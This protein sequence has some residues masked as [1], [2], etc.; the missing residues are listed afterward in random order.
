[1]YNLKLLNINCQSIVNK[2]AEFDALLDKHKPDIVV[3][4]ESWLIP[5]HIDSEVFPKS[6]GFALFRQDRELGTSGGGVFILVKDTLIASEQKQMKTECEI[7]WVKFEMTTTKPLYVAAYYKPRY[8]DNQS[9]AELRRSLELVH[10]LKGNTWLLGDFNYPKFSWDQDHVPTMKSGSSLPTHY[11]NF[12]SLLDD[13]S[14]V[15]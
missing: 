4:T 6:L 11:D 12:V 2:K 5:N 8:G 10:L 14:L 9:T 15:P 13:F 3:G 1:M 7:I